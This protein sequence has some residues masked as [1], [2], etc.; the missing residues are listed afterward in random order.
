MKSSIR[1]VFLILA[2]V[3]SMSCE[4]DDICIDEVTPKLIIRFYDFENPELFKDVANLKVNIEGVEEDYANETI[5]TLTDSIS[6]P[7]NVVGNQTRYILTLQENEIL[8]QEENSD[9]VEIT[10]TQEDLFV[11][12]PC[13]Y[14]AVFN[15]VEIEV[16]EDG[17]NWIDD[18]VPQSDP[19]D[20]NN[21]S[22]AHVKIY[23]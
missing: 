10:Y 16:E 15:G 9:I 22:A 13:G 8:G 17:E 21:E 20:I 3:L 4:R 2:I 11:S 14:K 7:I 12:R 1:S 5:T 23:H 19:L 6:L 18:I